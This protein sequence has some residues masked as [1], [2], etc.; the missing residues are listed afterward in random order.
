MIWIKN[1]IE[2]ATRCSLKCSVESC[3]FVRMSHTNLIVKFQKLKVFLIYICLHFSRNTCESKQ[4]NWIE[5]CQHHL[6]NEV[7]EYQLRLYR[8]TT[9]HERFR[10]L[11]E[12]TNELIQRFPTV[13]TDLSTLPLLSNSAFLISENF[14]N[15]GPIIYV[16]HQSFDK[17]NNQMIHFLDFYDKLN[18]KDPMPKCLV[19]CK[20]DLNSYNDPSNKNL[21]EYAWM[22]KFIDISV[23][24]VCSDG[25]KAYIYTFNPFINKLGKTVLSDNSKI[26]P[27][28]FVNLNKHPLRLG[29]LH[30]PP[31]YTITKDINGNKVYDGFKF[32]FLKVMLKEMNFLLVILELN[33]S[34]NLT[35]YYFDILEKLWTQKYS[36]MMAPILWT[37]EF[38]VLPSLILND[39][40]VPY[41]GIIELKSIVK[42]NLSSEFIIFFICIPVAFV[43]FKLFIFAL[44][45]K[46]FYFDTLDAIRLLLGMSLLS[47][48]KSFLKRF[49]LIFLFFIS[50][51]FS[52][53]FIASLLS[54][55]TTYDEL[56]F[57]SMEE[58][59]N[60]DY[61][62]SMNKVVE[63][64]IL[65][66]EANNTIID[67]LKQKISN[68]F[69]PN[70]TMN[71]KKIICVLSM[72]R[73]REVLK[74]SVSDG[75]QVYK[76]IPVKFGCNVVAYNFERASPFIRRFESMFLKMYESGIYN[77]ILKENEKT[78]DSF[79]D[80]K[81]KKIVNNLLLIN[82]I[83]LFTFGLA[84]S[85]ITF[86]FEILIHN[87]L[88]TKLLE[89]RNINRIIF[90]LS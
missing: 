85:V 66:S 84:L 90:T 37:E 16:H 64:I 81:Q 33:Q 74:N 69:C 19:I 72:F 55:L 83:L 15:N 57:N 18:A 40:C 78:N 23:L 6:A 27:N 82:L 68:V 56:T 2:I 77:W 12:F 30:Y 54:T 59:I 50:M 34:R 39:D 9:E 31:Y 73:A 13:E 45:L 25:N 88:S 26:F 5:I 47:F 80:E 44:K 21:L 17:L 10:E 41:V 11:S 89:V 87:L 4:L 63:S 71:G 28:K 36:M 3:T 58:I 43:F 79:E 75:R 48:P 35:S 70:S 52:I 51:I 76:M 46:T 20:N 86:I 67:V 7:G 60:S 24:E 49:I 29:T 42:F 61:K 8:N 14:S 22:K 32:K 53:D 1:K 38:S 62:L 65:K